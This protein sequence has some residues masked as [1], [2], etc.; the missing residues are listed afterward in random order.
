MNKAF[1]KGIEQDL[2]QTYKTTEYA[3]GKTPLLF[4][5][6]KEQIYDKKE[7]VAQVKATTEKSKSNMKMIFF[8]S[9]ETGKNI[10]EQIKTVS[11]GKFD[12]WDIEDLV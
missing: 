3:N 10:Q 8:T 2:Y 9:K 1:L 4:D 5:D 6:W 12:E 11:S 7:N